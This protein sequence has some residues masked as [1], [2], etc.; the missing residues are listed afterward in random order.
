MV[1]NLVLFL[2]GCFM[3]F[4]DLIP[5][6]SGG[7]IAFITGIYPRLIKSV[8]NISPYLIVL[9]VKRLFNPTDKNRA[10]LKSGLKAIDIKF[11][12]ILF[13]GVGFAIILFSRFINFLLDNYFV[14]TI[15]FFIGLI[16]ASSKL[17]FNC[18]DRHSFFDI[19]FGFFGLIG[20]GLFVVV[21]PFSIDPGYLYLFFGGF[22][23]INAMF[24]PGISG[25]FILLTMGL[26]QFMIR[27]LANLGNYLTHFLV[28]A[29]GALLGAFTISRVVSFFLNKQ[30]NKTFY[31]LLGLVVGSLGVSVRNIIESMPEINFLN[32]LAVISFVF[33]GSLV[34]ILLGLAKKI[35]NSKSIGIK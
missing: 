13:L 30:K 11:I 25:A 16:L 1:D 15:S 8:K 22:C 2:K 33:S 12:F 6:I 9:M 18:L 27:V 28:F 10:R 23:A 3:G 19:L 4:C 24:L 21:D 32:I 31:F 35:Y 5:G 7:T 34:F 29:A 20:G 14:Y 26:Y 17:I